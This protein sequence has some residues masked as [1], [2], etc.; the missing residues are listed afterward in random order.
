MS[1]PFDARI[2]QRT[3]IAAS[4]EKVFETITSS[5]G[6]DAFFT[7]GMKL[8]PKPGGECT[9][10]WKDWGPDFYSLGAPGKVVAVERPT[11]FS[12][13]W[14]STGKETT[15]S[16]ELEAKHGGTVL[17][18]TEDGY[19]NTPEGRAMILECA[20]GWGEACTLL[21]FYLEHGVTYTPPKRDE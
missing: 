19:E 4:P 2:K 21:K 10:K 11:L 9:F 17:T 16:F 6:W 8:D 15:I 7:T 12:F 20:S 14:G 1:E 5:D 18:C 3:F 13:Q